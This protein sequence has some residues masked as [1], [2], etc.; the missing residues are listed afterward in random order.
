MRFTRLAL[1]VGAAASLF[2]AAPLTSTASAA[3]R[4]TYTCDH[5]GPAPLIYPPWVSGIDCV[6]SPGAPT[7]GPVNEPIKLIIEH[8]GFSSRGDSEARFNC[9]R[10]QV[11]EDDEGVRSVMGRGC[12]PEERDSD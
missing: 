12:F 5:D 3:D 1:T 7:S 9:E 11:R 10:A 4:P 2:A 8:P 6:A